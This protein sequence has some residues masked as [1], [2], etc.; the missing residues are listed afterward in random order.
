MVSWGIENFLFWDARG[1]VVGR[2]LALRE[3]SGGKDLGQTFSDDHTSCLGVL[4]VVAFTRQVT[5]Y[6]LLTSRLCIHVGAQVVAGRRNGA[7]ELVRHGESGR[8]M[9]IPLGLV[10]Q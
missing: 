7:R 2:R 9:T 3:P 8:L 1:A 4:A 5:N 6:R 10:R